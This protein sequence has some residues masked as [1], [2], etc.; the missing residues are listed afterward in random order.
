VLLWSAAL[1]L[2]IVGSVGGLL[3]ASVLL[4]VDHHWQARIVPWF[5]SY[6]VGTLLGAAL[7]GLLPEALTV[8]EPS[9]AF[10]TLLGGI[11]AFF[12]LEKVVLWRHCHVDLDEGCEIHPGTVALILIG[13]AV[14]TFVDGAVIAAATLVSLPLGATTALAVAAHEIPQEA[15][16][17]AV[18][19]AAGQTRSRAL[20]LN[21]TSA[22]GAIAGAALMLLFGS[23]LPGLVPFVLAFAAGNFLY[24][25]M[26]DLIPHLHRGTAD[27][28]PA[29]QVILIA[30]GVLTIVGL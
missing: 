21:L 22:G 15:G 4:L 25:A 8:L 16:D 18:L 20:L 6:A 9:A 12:L 10:G 13:D 2:S 5:V 3:T 11:L 27:R 7:L 19:L 28:N 17:F 30:L 26:A 29:R 14:H 1:G 23:E 24:V